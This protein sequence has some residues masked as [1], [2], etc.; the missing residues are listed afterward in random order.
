[1]LLLGRCK[2]INYF[3]SLFRKEGCVMGGFIIGAVIGL[4]VGA[5]FGFLTACL[6]AANHDDNDY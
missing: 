2:R 3:L 1:M 4:V 5:A 6:V